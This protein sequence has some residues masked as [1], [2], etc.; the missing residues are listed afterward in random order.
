MWTLC[1]YLIPIMKDLQLHNGDVQQCSKTW[2]DPEKRTPWPHNIPHNIPHISKISRNWT[3]WTHFEAPKNLAPSPSSQPAL[4]K[5]HDALVAVLVGK[6]FTFNISTLTVTRGT[7]FQS[8]GSVQIQ[9]TSG[10]RMNAPFFHTSH[11]LPLGII[12]D[13]LYDISSGSTLTANGCVWK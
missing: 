4:P 3:H 10:M 7:R 2:K 9:P 5:S 11:T 13:F 1:T 6:Q 12:F 8:T